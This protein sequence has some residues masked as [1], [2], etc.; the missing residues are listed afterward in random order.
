MQKQNEIAEGVSIKYLLEEYS[1]VAFL[2]MRA[3]HAAKISLTLSVYTLITVI[4]TSIHIIFLKIGFF[5]DLNIPFI[6]ELSIA[7]YLETFLHNEAKC[8]NYIEK[9]HFSE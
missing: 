4:W 1:K 7:P 3:S 8:K 6:S 5:T 9:Y 2:G